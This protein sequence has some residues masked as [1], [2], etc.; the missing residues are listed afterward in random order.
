MRAVWGAAATEARTRPAELDG[1]D[2]RRAPLGVA[3]EPVRAADALRVLVLATAAARELQV[4][5]AEEWRA[6]S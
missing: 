1:L 6:A 4:T 3:Q 2:L 5:L